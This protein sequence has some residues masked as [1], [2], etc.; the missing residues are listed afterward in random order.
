MRI[1]KRQLRRIIREA[2]SDE[3]ILAMADAHL[4]KLGPADPKAMYD[5]GFDDRLNH[6]DPR[7]PEDEDYMQGYRDGGDELAPLPDEGIRRRGW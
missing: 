6:H 1:T 4:E 2:M 3:E 7:Q 5:L